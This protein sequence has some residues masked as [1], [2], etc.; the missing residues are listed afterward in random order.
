MFYKAKF[1]IRTVNDEPED[2]L[3][4]LIMEIRFWITSKLN[5]RDQSQVISYNLGSWS[6][7]KK[8]GKLYDLEHLNR[9]YAESIYHQASEKSESVSWA[10][11]IVENPVAEN[12][13][14]PR[15]WVTQIGYRA[16]S[17]HSA[18]ISYVVTYSDMAGFIGFCQETPSPNVPR[19]MRK[20]LEDPTLVC[21]VGP[22]QI[23]QSAIK[24]HVGDYPDFEKVLFDP[25]REIPIIYISPYY[26]DEMEDAC[27]LIN[28][29]RIAD[30][31]AANALVYYS[32]S[33]GFTQEMNYMCNRNYLCSGGAI[34][35]YRPHINREDRSDASR[36]RFLPASF[37]EE[38]GEDK[39]VDMFRRAMAQDVYFYEKLFRMADC[40]A[41]VE[42]DT[43]K[44]RIDRIREQSQG[45][46]DEATQLFLVESEQR[47]VAELKCEELKEEIRRLKTEKF[48]IEYQRDTYKRRAECAQEVEQA[49]RNTRSIS[50]YPST[51]QA[52]AK[53]FQTVFPDRIVFT[54][55][56]FCSMAE[57]TTKSEVLWEAFYCMVNDLFDLI[58]SN[59][60]NAYTEFKRITGWE[61]ARCEG[62]QTRNDAKM[63]R[64]YI[65][66]YEGQEI[67]IEAHVKNGTRESDPKFVRI[68]FA[69]DPNITDRIIVGH[70]G[71]HLEN[72]SSRKARR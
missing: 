44:R 11:K 65:D 35:V 17:D 69:Y 27:L 20:L 54:E 24:L 15:Q 66:T 68:Y 47:E 45:E 39:I 51:P 50:E 28:P 26:D 49:V 53:Y 64:Q 55:R 23:S 12:G 2:L 57:C 3:W 32:D 67:D 4:K 56:A 31:V 16:T 19:V 59:P 14:A 22:N 9:V 36:H 21:S 60:A 38:H 61:I 72:F 13:C 10:C 70:C 40:R 30:S 52:I 7:F 43:H 41:L 34:R 33:L 63:M 1:T 29:D 6:H 5:R 42:A 18:E 71:K 8:G 37:I 58:K 46:T 48:G 25:E 62:S